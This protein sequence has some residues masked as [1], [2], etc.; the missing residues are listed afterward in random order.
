MSLHHS[1][2]KFL[3][4]VNRAGVG[5]SALDTIR[6][7]DFEGA[8]IQEVSL[9]S[10][11]DRMLPCA[12]DIPVRIYAADECDEYPLM[13]FFHGGGFVRGGIRDHHDVLCRSLARATGYKIISVGYRLAPEHKFPAALNDCYAATKWVYQNAEELK[14]DRSTLTV[15]GNSA[16]GNLATVVCLLASER[17][18]FSVRRQVLC[19]PVTDY[20]QDGEQR[21]ASY[22][23]NGSGYYLTS[24]RMSEY[25]SMYLNLV[26]EGASPYASPIRA[27]NLSHMPATLILTA[28]YDPLRDE[29]EQYACRLLT[30]GVPVLIRRCKGMLHGFLNILNFYGTK[31]DREEVMGLVGDF[32]KMKL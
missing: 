21:Y 29:A 15:F 16:G 2:L 4:R 25:W 27:K 13:I 20:Y 11:E 18:E 12:A 28:E 30:S 22:Q 6:A 9:V 19:Y 10:I 26:E 5:D 23:E 3:E 32:L 1:M 17:G 8:S 7:S 31:K 14:G 24:K